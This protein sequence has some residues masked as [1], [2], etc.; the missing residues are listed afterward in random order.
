M[1]IDIKAHHVKKG[2]R[3]APKSQDPYLLLL[4]KLYRFLAR[5]TDSRFNKVVLHRLF[6]SKINRPPLSLSR[7]SRLTE[8]AP[9]RDSKIIV[10]VGT[11]TDDIRQTEVPKLRIA[12]LR[13]TRAAK[14]RILSAG[15]EVLTLDQLALRAP[16]GSNTILLRGE[17]TAREAVKHFGMGPHKHKKPYTIS[18]GRK[19]EQG[20]G[21]RKSRGF[22]RLALTF[23]YLDV[24][25]PRNLDPSLNVNEVAKLSAPGDAA[26]SGSQARS[27]SVAGKGFQDAEGSN[28]HNR[29][30]LGSTKT[31]EDLGRTAQQAVLVRQKA[32][33]IETEA[34]FTTQH[35]L[36]AST[37]IT[38][39]AGLEIREVVRGFETCRLKIYNLPFGAKASEIVELFTQQG[40]SRDHFHIL[41]IRPAGEAHLEAEVL[42]RAGE[43]RV[44]AA[45]LQGIEFRNEMLGFEIHE[46][47]DFTE[48][49]SFNAMREPPA[50]LP[51]TLTITW[52]APCATMIATYTTMKEAQVRAKDLAGRIIAGPRIRAEISK[53]PTGSTLHGYSR[54]PCKSLGSR[55][56]MSPSLPTFCSWLE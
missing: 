41:S 25:P 49:N 1:G 13:F 7:I 35:I 40:M 37:F 47:F 23:R 51:D 16:T 52:S 6:Q 39:G 56:T 4:V 32:L 54:P 27:P 5:R 15:G 53:R 19:F 10:N 3:T 22:K 30:L 55:A 31:F 29:N 24:Q 36:P 21:R 43:G 44:I 33:R 14:E 11:V 46:R 34:A 12:A 42:T 8:N 20:R 38:C 9:E 17:K 28:S 2:Q 45:G 26:A 50:Q 48:T 18:K